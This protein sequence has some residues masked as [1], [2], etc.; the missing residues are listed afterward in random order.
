MLTNLTLKVITTNE[1]I[2]LIFN[3]FFFMSKIK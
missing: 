1:I 2:F 3:D